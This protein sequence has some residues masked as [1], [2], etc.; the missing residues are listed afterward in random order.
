MA[1]DKDLLK[2]EISAFAL[3][4]G[5]KPYARLLMEEI[6]DLEEENERLSEKV[7]ELQQQLKNEKR[8]NKMLQKKLA[9]EQKTEKTP[10]RKD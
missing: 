5:A 10:L 6:G 4:T 1:V 7:E 3:L 9:E 2:K 8:K